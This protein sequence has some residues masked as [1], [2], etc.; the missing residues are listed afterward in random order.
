M[1]KRKPETQGQEK[2]F[3]NTFP[4]LI[5]GMLK[6]VEDIINLQLQLPK[7]EFK[8]YHITAPELFSPGYLQS[9]VIL[10]SFSAELLLKYTIGKEGKK[11][12]HIHDLYKLYELLEDSTKE[13]IESGYKE[14]MSNS[15]MEIINEY[16]D[17]KSV[18]DNSREHFYQWRYVS[19]PNTN[20]DRPTTSYPQC[21]HAANLSI[22]N[23]IVASDDNANFVTI[24]R[25]TI[26]ERQKIELAKQ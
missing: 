17:V 18:Y 6:S 20:T 5:S 7:W 9:A 1:A 13:S 19:T 11:F 14:L 25:P 24:R 21:I 26:N 4:I 22:Y 2:E 15:N 10:S 16:E 23:N 3:D 12:P 8:K